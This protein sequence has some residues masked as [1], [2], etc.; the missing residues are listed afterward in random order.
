MSEKEARE[1]LTNKRLKQ[2]KADIEQDSEIKEAHKP[3]SDLYSKT[4]GKDP[5]TGVE[6][7]TEDAVEEAKEWASNQNR[8]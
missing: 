5:E 2:V 7:P 4:S 3:A 1:N 6:I 8:R